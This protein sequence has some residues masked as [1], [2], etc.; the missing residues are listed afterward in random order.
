MDS[1]YEKQLYTEVSAHGEAVGLPAGNM[2]NSEVG[3][4]TMGAGRAQLQDL[5]RIN[6]SISDNKFAS[7]PTLVSTFQHVLDSKK[8]LHF[9]GLVSD[10]GVHSHIEHLK[11]FLRAAKAKG[12]PQ[13]YIH[14]FA[15]GRDTAPTSAI[16]YAADLQKFMK[17]I[18]YGSI[19]TVTGR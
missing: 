10:G 11:A 19:A 16:K 18:Q 9:A 5:S 13:A 1:F 2:G 6:A 14:F 7:N 8:K 17:E 15:D 3:H 12:I 4:L